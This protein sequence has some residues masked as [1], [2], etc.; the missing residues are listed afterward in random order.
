M[1]PKGTFELRPCAEAKDEE[2]LVAEHAEISRLRPI[3]DGLDCW[4]EHGGCAG[5]G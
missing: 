3:Q 5:T 2:V 4:E 1:A